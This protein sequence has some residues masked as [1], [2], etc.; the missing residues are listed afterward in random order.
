[1]QTVET[2][3]IRTEYWGNSIAQWSAALLTVVFVLAA[4]RAIGWLLR[5]KLENAAS[6]KTQ[7]DDMACELV[8]RTKLWL[9]FFPVLLFAAR[10][11]DLPVAATKTIR[12][13]AVIAFLIQAGVWTS[14]L[15]TFWIARVQR[16]KMETDAAAATTISALGFVARVVIWAVVLLLVLDNL[17]FQITGL[18]A[19]LGIGGIAVALAAQ[20][21][22]GDL[23]A[24]ASI[25][26]DKPFVI[27]DFIAVGDFLGTVEYIGL[28]TTR[29]R[30][31][32]GEQIIFSNTDLLDSRVRNFKRMVERRIAF[33]LGVTYQ[34]PKAKVEK[35]PSIIQGIID[36]TANARFDR[37][38]FKTFG[39]FSLD[40]ETVY[41][42]LSPEFAVYMDTQQQINLEIME[43]FEREQIEFA[44]PTQTLFVER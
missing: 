24:S 17:G 11:L 38:H 12:D 33:T 43:A 23:F 25:V 40:V 3:L 5:R 37:S 18:V 22:L 41:W 32:G 21:V 9:I 2:E 14:A 19:G 16:S 8:D 4:I 31:L 1:M 42:V 10:W 39:S 6:T 13:V 7:I 29:L 28:K 34:T 27:G 15:A 20:K 30:S 36:A 35:I 44:Y 26:I